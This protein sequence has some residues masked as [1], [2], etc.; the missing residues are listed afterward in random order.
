MVEVE[1][2]VETPQRKK[3][4]SPSW[5]DKMNVDCH[6]LGSIYIHVQEAHDMN[7]AQLL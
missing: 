5:E 1:A 7:H 6:Q 2:V 4:A 3:V